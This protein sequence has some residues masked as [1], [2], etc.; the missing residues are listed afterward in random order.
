M[1]T[2]FMKLIFAPP[3]II[4][5]IIG[6]LFLTRV[7]SRNIVASP[8]HNSVVAVNSVHAAIFITPSSF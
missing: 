8:I 2:I 7:E 6:W 5:N 3:I 1:F 4:T